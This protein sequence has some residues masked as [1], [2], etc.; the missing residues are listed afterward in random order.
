MNCG[1]M[2]QVPFFTSWN[3]Q[4]NDELIFLGLQLEVQMFSN[5]E[6]FLFRMCFFLLV[7]WSEFQA[8][9]LGQ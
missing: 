4:P 9:T 1:T 6:M 7:F 2:L 3:L 8:K 5:I